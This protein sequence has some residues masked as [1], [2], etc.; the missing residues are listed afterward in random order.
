MICV[1]GAGFEVIVKKI[2]NALIDGAEMVG[3]GAVLL[4]AEGEEVIDERGE[5]VGGARGGGEA[6]L[7]DFAEL[8]VEIGDKLIVVTTLVNR[9][10]KGRGRLGHGVESVSMNRF[11]S[12]QSTRQSGGK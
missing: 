6:G 4:A 1:G 8:Q 2:L 11:H 7:A 9:G 3:E 5:T 12:K 10:G